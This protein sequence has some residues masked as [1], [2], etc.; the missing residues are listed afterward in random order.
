MPSVRISPILHDSWSRELHQ[1]HGTNRLLTPTPP[2]FETAMT[3]G[4]ASKLLRVESDY[5]K[6]VL[7]DPLHNGLCS[8]ILYQPLDPIDFL[9]NYLRYWVQYVRTYRREKIAEKQIEWLF[10]IQIPWNISVIAEQAKKLEQEALDDARRIAAEEARKAA[11]ERIRIKAATDVATKRTTDKIRSD[12]SASIVQDVVEN[13]VDLA[14][15]KEEAAE[16]AKIL[17]EQR[18]RQRALEEEE[19][20]ELKEESEDA[21]DA[22]EEEEEEG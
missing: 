10:T 2:T 4:A 19:Q 15:R 9:S 20:A 14:V 3:E 16:R 7:G 12:T 1:R 6:K 21:V 8:L 22:N 17:A 5:I 11:Q 18:A 13:S